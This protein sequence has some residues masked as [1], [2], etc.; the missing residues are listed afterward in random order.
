MSSGL[1]DHIRPITSLFAPLP[2]VL[3]SLASFFSLINLFSHQPF[4]I[5]LSYSHTQK[6]LLT[7]VI[8]LL[9]LTHSHS[10]SVLV[11]RCLPPVKSFSASSSEIPINTVNM[12]SLTLLAFLTIGSIST[13]MPALAT[14]DKTST[15]HFRSVHLTKTH[16]RAKTTL[17]PY[18][19]LDISAA[20]VHNTSPL[21]KKFTDK[22]TRS[23][24]VAQLQQ[25]DRHA[26]LSSQEAR[27]LPPF[28]SLALA[29]ASV[30][31][32]VSPTRQSRNV[33]SSAVLVG[34]V[35]SKPASLMM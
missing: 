1:H 32:V 14:D 16:H 15:H 9:P 26:L 17:L 4:E 20:T 10:L 33:P 3:T 6:E 28:M 35:H 25:R 34:T 31:N 30:L 27:I 22:L 8:R 5:F 13:F 12:K 21:T 19:T 29:S 2:R 24:Q 23:R 11:V 7:L 18:S